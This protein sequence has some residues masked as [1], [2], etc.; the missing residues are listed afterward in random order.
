[1]QMKITANMMSA[2]PEGAQEHGV[3]AASFPLPCL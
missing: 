1:M 3:I 2:T